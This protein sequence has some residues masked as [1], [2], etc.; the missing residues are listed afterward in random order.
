M[1]IVH[2][3]HT[4]IYKTSKSHI[5]FAR[6]SGI[7][8]A[9]CSCGRI[10]LS[11]IQNLEVKSIDKHDNPKSNSYRENE[12]LGRTIYK[13]VFTYQLDEYSMRKTCG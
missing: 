11:K 9:T 2:I 8:N 3:K 5:S 13:M 1:S 10:Y 7:G 4:Y 6:N 12:R